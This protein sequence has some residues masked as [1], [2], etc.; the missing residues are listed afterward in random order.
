M[1][2]QR[3]AQVIKLPSISYSSRLARCFNEEK[4][5]EKEEIENNKIKNKEDIRKRR[6]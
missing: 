4:T 5:E 1:K 2:T 3:E 6:R